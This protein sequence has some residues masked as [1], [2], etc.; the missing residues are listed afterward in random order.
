MI[1][2]YNNEGNMKFIKI[3]DTVLD[4]P[5]RMFCRLNKP[6]LLNKIDCKV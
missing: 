1:H 3:V 2:L 6:K 5:D 4:T